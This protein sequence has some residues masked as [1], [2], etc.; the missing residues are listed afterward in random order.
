MAGQVSGFLG[1]ASA[2]EPLA[3][4]HQGRWERARL[5]RRGT[6]LAARPEASKG[7]CRLVCSCMW[8]PSCEVRQPRTHLWRL[9]RRGSAAC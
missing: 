5:R 9:E 2:A 8:T 3:L 4:A 6:A 7:S 1:Q